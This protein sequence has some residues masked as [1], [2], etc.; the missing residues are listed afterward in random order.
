DA[1]NKNPRDMPPPIPF[2]VAQHRVI[3]FPTKHDWRHDA[4]ITLIEAQLDGLRTM[5]T[6]LQET[7]PGRILIP[8][9][10]CGLGGL[11]WE[12]VKARCGLA[13]LDKEPSVFCEP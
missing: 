3:L 9:L 1:Y 5:G 8:R 6:A 2:C 4:N 11:S 13:G 7:Q 12:T 10:G